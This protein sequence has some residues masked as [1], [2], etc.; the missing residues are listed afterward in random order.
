MSAD[1]FTVDAARAGQR[2]DRLVAA[3]PSVGSRQRARDAIESGKISLNGQIIDT[4]YA[5]RPLSEGATL[6][7][8]WNRPGTA[9]RQLAGK[10]ALQRAGVRVLHQDDSIIVVDK[11]AGL[12]TDAATGA[13]RRDDDTLKKR[14]RGWLANTD[15]H[16]VHRIDRDTTGLVLF[17]RTK[18]SAAHLDAQF[19]ARQPERV[20]HT[21]VRGWI[22]GDSGIF[23]DWMAWDARSRLQRVSTAGAPGAVEASAEWRVL[24][25]LGD[26]ATLIEVRLHS[27]RRNQIRLHCMLAG[28]PLIGERL[29]VDDRPAPIAFGRQ[30]LHA[31][32]LGFTHPGTGK[33]VRYESPM[34]DDMAE[35]LSRLRGRQRR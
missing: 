32:A 24:E 22:K 10:A 15:P 11:P 28:H 8:D 4:T 33:K 6:E 5:P 31:A 34:A 17:A 13:Q 20:Y 30:A 14:V 35:L 21:V 27:G 18:Q 19:A 12:L 9:S 25:R 26:G 1:S 23:K 16:V 29:Y 7:V 3:I 2:L